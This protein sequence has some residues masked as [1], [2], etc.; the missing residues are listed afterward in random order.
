MNSRASAMIPLKLRAPSTYIGPKMGKQE[1]KMEKF[2]GV[3][4]LN[5]QIVDATAISSD[6]NLLRA[7]ATVVVGSR[8]TSGSG[9]P[10]GEVGNGEVGNANGEVVAS[11][12]NDHVED[13]IGPSLFTSVTKSACDGC[14]NTN[15]ARTDFVQ[16]QLESIDFQQD[17]DD[18]EFSK[19]EFS[20]P[21]FSSVGFSTD[22]EAVR[23]SETST[24]VL[25]EGVTAQKDVE[26]HGEASLKVQ[27]LAGKKRGS[28]LNPTELQRSSRDLVAE[29]FPKKVVEAQSIKYDK[30]DRSKEAILWRNRERAKELGMSQKLVKRQELLEE[31]K[32]E[33][34]FSKEKQ[35][36][37]VRDA[38]REQL[39]GGSGMARDL[40]LPGGNSIE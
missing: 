28:L 19:P 29:L 39:L 3:A 5:L 30:S 36:K 12:R 33:R 14:R 15:D 25:S 6:S 4:I 35:K 13:N 40:K 32:A 31:R 20:K 26:E 24:Q 1:R 38:A 9:H 18:A 10:N 27:A 23:K 37:T 34:V 16:N 11:S 22:L 8:S 2:E 7:E 21:A 17:L